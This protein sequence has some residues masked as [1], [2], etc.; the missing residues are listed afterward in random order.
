[1]KRL[2]GGKL[3]RLRTNQGGTNSVINITNILLF[4]A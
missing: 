4:S 1:M 3:R 2:N